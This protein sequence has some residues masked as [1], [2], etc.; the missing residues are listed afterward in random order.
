MWLQA[1]RDPAVLWMSAPT[2]A[3]NGCRRR[4]S[5]VFGLGVI[6]GVAVVS[7]SVGLGSL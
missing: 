2:E 3:V 5:V 6:V 4:R 1:V 7:V